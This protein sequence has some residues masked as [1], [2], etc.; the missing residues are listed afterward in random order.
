[1]LPDCEPESAGNADRAFDY[2]S[3]PT[4][5]ASRYRR[6]LPARLPLRRLQRF[7]AARQQ[8]PG[9]GAGAG[10]TRAPYR[11]IARYR[12]GGDPE[13]VV[14]HR[15][16]TRGVRQLLVRHHPLHR[17]RRRAGLAVRPGI[18]P[19]PSGPSSV[20][21]R[22]DPRPAGLPDPPDRATATLRP[23]RRR[24]A[25]HLGGRLVGRRC[26]CPQGPWR[27]DQPARGI[28]VTAC[29][30]GVVGGGRA[31]APRTLARHSHHRVALRNDHRAGDRRHRQPLGARRDHGLGGGADRLRRGQ[32]VASRVSA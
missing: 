32:V 14:Q 27:P 9:A 7:A 18:P 13:P 2:P 1:M 21:D 3:V 4:L 5:C 22:D 25:A 15:P 11:E 20:G 31:A 30:L 16:L 19:L 8:R 17:H 28:P 23:L 29:R 10:R 24:L 26:L 6:D 12:L